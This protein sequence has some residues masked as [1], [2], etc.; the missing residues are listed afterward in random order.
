MSL[1]TFVMEYKGG[2]YA[3][4][5]A[6]LTLETACQEWA[7]QLDTKSICG[8]NHKCKQ[9]LVEEMKTQLM[10][11]RLKGLLNVWCFTP[12]TLEGSLINIIKTDN[13]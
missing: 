1:F 2:T 9:M 5:V 13:L 8:L 6:A 7:L 4:Q 3:S 10:P 12:L 11:T